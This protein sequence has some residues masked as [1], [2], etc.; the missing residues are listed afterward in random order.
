MIYFPLP[1]FLLL[2]FLPPRNIWVNDASLAVGERSSVPLGDL[3]RQRKSERKKLKTKVIETLF[4]KVD[5]NRRFRD[6]F[7]I[8]SDKV[9]ETR[10]RNIVFF[11]AL[12]RV[13]SLSISQTDV[14][15]SAYIK[16]AFLFTRLLAINVSQGFFK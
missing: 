8:E 11:F 2:F 16:S 10:T 1:F 7:E 6:S 9:K 12:E 3:Q 5:V 4:A 13:S 14:Q 15:S